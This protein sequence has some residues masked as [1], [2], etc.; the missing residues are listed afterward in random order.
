MDN[1]EKIGEKS[2]PEKEDFYCQMN[3]EAITNAGY[4]HTKRVCKD[5]QTKK[6]LYVVER[7]CN[8]I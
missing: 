4:L 7:L 8:K 1:W 2:L 6:K 5:F 3:M